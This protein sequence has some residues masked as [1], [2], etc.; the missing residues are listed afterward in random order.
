MDSD[1]KM[2]TYGIVDHQW[3]KRGPKFADCMCGHVGKMRTIILRT[4]WSI[5]IILSNCEIQYLHNALTDL[6]EIWNFGSLMHLDPSDTI[7]Q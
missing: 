5:V 2:R 3:V 7:S 4:K 6:D 1:C